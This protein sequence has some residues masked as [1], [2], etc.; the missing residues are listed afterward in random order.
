MLQRFPILL[1]QVEADNAS[2]KLLNKIR[3]IVYLL[4]QTKQ[5]TKKEY[6]NLLNT[7]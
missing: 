7:V 3:Q 2:K 5:I 6:N 4:Y 1:P